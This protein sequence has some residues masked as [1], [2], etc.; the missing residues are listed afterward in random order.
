M[1][2][3]SLTDI[4]EVFQHRALH[5]QLVQVSI[6]QRGYPLRQRAIIHGAIGRH[7]EVLVLGAITEVLDPLAEKCL[8]AITPFQP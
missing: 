6:Q 4:R 2:A 3:R 5:G 7:D 8:V 1:F